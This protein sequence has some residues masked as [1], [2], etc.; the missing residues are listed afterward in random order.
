V[1][2]NVWA[3]WCG[4]CAVEL[5]HLVDAAQRYGTQVQFLGVDTKD[6]YA[7]AQKRID[8]FGIPYPSVADPSGAIMTSLGFLGPPDTI[9]FDAHGVARSTISGPITVDQLRTELRGIL[10]AQAG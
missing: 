5:P 3:G 4:P 6:Q 10:P 7:L 8:D 1:V 9:F 2:L